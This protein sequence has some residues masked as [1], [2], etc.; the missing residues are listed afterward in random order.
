MPVSKQFVRVAYGVAA[1]P[2]E[3]D[4]S[5]VQSPNCYA[6]R[7]VEGLLTIIELFIVRT[8]LAASARRFVRLD[9][10]REYS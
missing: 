5:N 6:K 8:R 9:G 3:L 10:A 1:R 7:A 2:R 4:R